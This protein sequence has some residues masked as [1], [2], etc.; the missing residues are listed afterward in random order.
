MR[1]KNG[2]VCCSCDRAHVSK[3]LWSVVRPSRPAVD[4]IVEIFDLQS[5]VD[6]AREPEQRVDVGRARE[7]RRW[8]RKTQRSSRRIAVHR[9]NRSGEERVLFTRRKLLRGVHSRD[10]VLMRLVR[11]PVP[12]RE[13]CIRI[14]IAQ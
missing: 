5:E 10:S 8:T 14:L 12:P 1:P 2:I 9:W 6:E 13:R 4:E 3:L 11:G 7:A